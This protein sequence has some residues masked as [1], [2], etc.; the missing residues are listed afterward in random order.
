MLQGYQSTCNNHVDANH[1]GVCDTNGCEE[2]F[3]TVEHVDSNH[4]GKCDFAKCGASMEIVHTDKDRDGVCDAPDCRKKLNDTSDIDCTVCVDENCDEL[5]DVCGKPTISEGLT[6]ISNGTLTCS[7]VVE[8]GLDVMSLRRINAFANTLSEYGYNISILED[9]DDTVTD[10]V[11]ILIGKVKSR[12]KSFTFDPHDLGWQGYSVKSVENKII[13]LGGSYTSLNKA[14]D[15]LLE[16]GFGITA[17]T[18]KVENAIFLH[19]SAIENLTTYDITGVFVGESDIKNYV[20]AYDSAPESQTLA[21]FAQTIIYKQSGYW[22]DTI[23]IDEVYENCIS[24]TVTEKTG[25]EG[26]YVNHKNGNLEIIC[27]FPNKLCEKGEDY[28]ESKLLDKSGKVV[29]DSTTVNVRDVNYEMFGAIGDGDAEHDDIPAIRKCHEYAN[30]YGHNV[31]LNK[32]KTYYIGPKNLTKTIEIETNVDFGD[33]H[34]IIDDR[35]I[36]SSDALKGV[37]LFTIPTPGVQTFT[38]ANCEFIETVNKNGGI[39]TRATKLDLGLGYPALL[40]VVNSNQ[41]V[42]IR[43]GSNA[44]SGREVSDVILIDEH[45]NIDPST[46]FI[47]DFEQIT[48]IQA[49]RVDVEEMT[50]S[51]GVFTQRANQADS[52]NKTYCRNFAINRSNL[53]IK[54]LTY[55]VTDER[56]GEY[57]G[58]PYEAFLRVEYANNVRFYNCKLDGHRTYYI[59]GTKTGM[60]SK[61]L[62]A[63]TSNNI[64]WEKCI[65][66]NM[67]TDETQTETTKNIWGIMS[68][69]FSK[70]LAYIDSTLSC[71][72]AHC[73]IYNATIKGSKIEVIRIVGKGTLLVEDCEI[74]AA[75]SSN[76]VI[77]TREDYGSFWRGEVIFRNVHMHT[78]GS[79]PVNFFVGHWYNHDFGYST[80]LASEIIIENFTVD[81]AVEVRLFSQSFLSE[82]DSSLT[83]ADNI[84]PMKP[85]EKVTIKNCANTIF[86]L[87]TESEFF[88]D[89]EFTVE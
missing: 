87:P 47:Y 75:N 68:S 85:T 4:N 64:V 54:D 35:E 70:N 62:N 32:G 58:D 2:L 39:T 6:L 49:Y 71:F 72:D 86:V 38:A 61:V 20:I 45:G 9:S 81:K 1:D 41:K 13:V 16:N 89:T 29:F 18:E 11:E 88:K 80:E 50:I 26:F 34:F 28:F 21:T 27:E 77:S 56:L 73:G 74:Y 31:V 23:C 37:R 48:K 8:N 33:A 46:P 25:G 57:E 82:L 65:Q 12:G 30:F 59:P 78:K 60:G 36:P 44:N 66:T 19:E 79:G 53:V 42:Y 43:Y 63:T 7:L 10:G 5:C 84:N 24:I 67:F 83:I 40:K 76:T 15:Y 17:F 52:D 3:E 14:L 22:L 51:G 55:R 69:N